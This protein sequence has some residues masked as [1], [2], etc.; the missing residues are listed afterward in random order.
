MSW[1]RPLPHEVRLG[2]ADRR[3]AGWWG[4]D[5]ASR[6]EMSPTFRPTPGAKG[7]EHSCTPVLSSIPLLAT[8]E[9]INRATPA[10]MIAKSH[11]LTGALEALLRASKFHKATSGPSFR[12]ITPE[13]PYRGAQ[14]SLLLSPDDLMPRIFTRLI[15]AGVVG[16]ERQ[17]SVIRLSPVSLYNTFEE[18]GRVAE[19]LEAAL[20]SEAG[21]SSDVRDEVQ[22]DMIAKD[23]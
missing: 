9:I 6:F 1:R 11:R 5:A 20:E 15:R 8:L 17:P 23:R 21:E 22:R 18:V 19:V 16:D 13:A 7:Y 3:L 14:L 2:F 10:A 12:I 4:N